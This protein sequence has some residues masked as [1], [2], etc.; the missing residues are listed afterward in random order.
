MP[1]KEKDDSKYIKIKNNH[2]NVRF[3]NNSIKKVAT[4]QKICIS[5][6]QSLN[7]L[8]EKEKNDLYESLEF[9]LK[10]IGKLTNYKKQTQLVRYRKSQ[11]VKF[12]FEFVFRDFVFW[13]KDRFCNYSPLECIFVIKGLTFYI[14]YEV[15]KILHWG[16]IQK[17]E[18]HSSIKLNFSSKDHKQKIIKQEKQQKRKKEVEKNNEII[19]MTDQNQ[20]SL[21]KPIEDQNVN[22]LQL[23]QQNV[24]EADIDQMP[25]V[26]DNFFLDKIDNIFDK[27]TNYKALEKLE[28]MFKEKI[29]K[30]GKKGLGKIIFD[31][32]IYF[33]ESKDQINKPNF[34]PKT[35]IANLKKIQLIDIYRLDTVKIQDLF[36][37]KLLIYTHSSIDYLYNTIFLGIYQERMVRN[38]EIED[39]RYNEYVEDNFSNKNGLNNHIQEDEDNFSLNQHEQLTD[40][41][42]MK[43][44]SLILL[45]KFDLLK[46]LHTIEY[47]SFKDKIN[48][49]SDLNSNKKNSCTSLDISYLGNVKQAK[50]NIV[51]DFMAF[52]MFCGNISNELTI[53]QKE[54]YGKLY[55]A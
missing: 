3:I 54:P 26:E 5:K 28:K 39:F 33:K 18:I 48:G 9:N 35:Q 49:F 20:L 31:K 2:S 41:L 24:V 16:M 7:T 19:N 11:M 14:R 42:K 29:N 36:F 43:F 15:T 37:S 38:N 12:D 21:N 32:E 46:E 27:E 55:F 23:D 52:L 40:F 44:E 25:I 53:Y 22:L 45:D 47:D 51:F 10:C 1:K 13:L 6:C 34:T 8:E 30:R 50:K 17:Q 4:K